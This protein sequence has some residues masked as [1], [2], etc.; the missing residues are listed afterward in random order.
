MGKKHAFTCSQCGAPDLE[1]SGEGKLRCPFCG[2]I[3]SYAV[4]GPTVVI[5][6][7]ANVVFGKSA[8]VVIK[9]GLEIEDGANVQM[10]GKITLL[11]RASEEAITAAKLKLQQPG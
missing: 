6:K 4:K 8:N 3:Y 5:K 2:S 7:G 10:D 11:E 9:G 1:R